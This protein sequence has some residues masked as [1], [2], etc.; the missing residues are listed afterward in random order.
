MAAALAIEV[1]ISLISRL[2]P[3]LPAMVIS[4][5][6][7]TMASYAVLLASLAMW[8]GWI[9]RHFTDLLDSAARLL[10]RV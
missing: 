1:T 4:I 10:V 2:A 5:P 8:P 9:E 6:T 7:K 3:Q